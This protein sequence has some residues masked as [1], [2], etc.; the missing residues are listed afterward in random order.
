MARDS[1]DTPGPM[2][3]IA[4]TLTETS[5]NNTKHNAPKNTMRPNGENT[6][7]RCHGVA[8]AGVVKAICAAGMRVIPL[9]EWGG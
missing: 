6:I 8:V 4:T 2:S 5:L 9:L 1:G 3:P 7:Q